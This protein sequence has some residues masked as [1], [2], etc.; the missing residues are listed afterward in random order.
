MRAPASTISPA[1]RRAAP[2]NGATASGGLPRRS[3]PR[4]RALLA[5]YLD[6]VA[7]FN[8]GNESLGSIRGRPRSRVALL[9]P[10]DRLD[11]L[12]ARARHRAALADN[13]RGDARIK[14]V[15]IDGWT[16]LKAYVPPKERRGLVL[17]DPAFEQPDEFARLADGLL[18]AH[19]KWPTG[20]YLLWYPIKTGA[21][22]TDWRALR[23]RHCQNILRAE[24]EVAPARPTG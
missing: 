6:V 22:P 8:R 18:A 19:R 9:R 24:F 1:R 13:L 14:I 4:R 5:P 7:S 10:Q 17:I 12:R 3:S 16:A 23:K 15:A 11:R 20:I 21:G 2:A